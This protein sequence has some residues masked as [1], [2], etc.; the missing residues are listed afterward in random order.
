[1]GGSRG[2]LRQWIGKR[3]R[4]TSLHPLQSR[5]H[6]LRQLTYGVDVDQALTLKRL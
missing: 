3:H 4:I 1:V 2:L 5:I 6:D